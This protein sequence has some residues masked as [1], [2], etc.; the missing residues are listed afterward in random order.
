MDTVF[1]LTVQASSSW[2]R[3]KRLEL[4]GATGTSCRKV[5][6][7]SWMGKIYT[8]DMV[9]GEARKGLKVTYCTDTRP[10]EGIV[11]HAAGS[12]LFICEGMYG[13]PEKEG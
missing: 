13:E 3:R 6:H 8:P 9:M 5:R 11:K 10:T 12:D 4:S 2:I 1:R 7:W